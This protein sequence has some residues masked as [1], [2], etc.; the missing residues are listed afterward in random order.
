MLGSAIP[1][2]DNNALIPDQNLANDWGWEHLTIPL[3][4]E[5][6]I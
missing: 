1:E 2:M 3:D 6:G 5:R 4:D